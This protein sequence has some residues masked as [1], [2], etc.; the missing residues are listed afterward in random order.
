MY[1]NFVIDNLVIKSDI[2]GGFFD[3]KNILI[4]LSCYHD[5]YFQ[6]FMFRKYNGFVSKL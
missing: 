5:N 1:D 2:F 3:F 4:K 6:Y